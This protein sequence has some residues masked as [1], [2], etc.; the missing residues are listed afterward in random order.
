[1]ENYH[2]ILGKG[3]VLEQK[4]LVYASDFYKFAWAYSQILKNSPAFYVDAMSVIAGELL[5]IAGGELDI[6]DAG[7]FPLFLARVICNITK[8]E[9]F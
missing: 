2:R 7:V 3:V 8:Y 9:K 6:S 4:L 5:I 1:M